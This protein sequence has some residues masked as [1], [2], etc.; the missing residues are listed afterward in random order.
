MRLLSLVLCLFLLIPVDGLAQKFS[1]VKISLGSANVGELTSLGIGIDHVQFVANDEIVTE[2]SEDEVDIIRQHGYKTEVLID[3]V[4]KHYRGLNGPA[5][6]YKTTPIDGT[7]MNFALGHY[8]GYYTYDEMISIFKLMR[9]AFPHLISQLTQID[10]FH[11]IEGRPIYWL[12]V[13]NKPDEEQAGKNQIL[14][15][16]LHHAR[17]PGS[18][19]QMIYFLWH[20]LEN[21]D[22]DEKLRAL[23]DNTEMYFIPCINPDG[24]IYNITTNP[25]GG[26]MWRTNRRRATYSVVGVDLNRNYGYKWGI[27]NKGSQPNVGGETSRGMAPFSEPETQAVKWFVEKHQFK[28]AL[29]Y[30]SFSQAFIYPWGHENTKCPDSVTY[31]ALADVLTKEN[32]Y[33]QGNCFEML[34]YLANGSSED[35]MYGEQSTKNKVFAFTPEVGSGFYESISQII[36]TCRQSLASNINAAALLLPFLAVTPDTQVKGIEGHISFELSNSGFSKTADVKVVFEPLDNR[37]EHLGSRTY[38]A[39]DLTQPFKDS[40]EFRIRSG[41]KIEGLKYLVKYFNG[42]YWVSDTATFRSPAADVSIFPNPASTVLTIR[43]NRFVVSQPIEAVLFNN[44]GKAVKK[45][46]MDSNLLELD[47]RDLSSGVYYLRIGSTA[48]PLPIE[49]V[50]ITR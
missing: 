37:F 11:S 2:L 43:I 4:G 9:A 48:Q 34:G 39:I 21:Y 5:E 10:S 31:V 8:A 45:V 35:W 6:S 25:N 47:V 3:D 30:H 12:R 44:L 14:Y 40:I 27:D 1:R 49:R 13:S 23:L 15:T 29:N 33:R 41:V 36:P 16:S 22:K 38:T 28:I 42:Y 24:Y 19:S 46:V 20:L 32:D 18:L 7:P 17:E 50:C 26:G